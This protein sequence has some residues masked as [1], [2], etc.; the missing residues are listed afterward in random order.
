MWF[1]GNILTLY[2]VFFFWENTYTFCKT[3][4]LMMET[5]SYSVFRIGSD[6]QSTLMKPA[7]SRLFVFL[8]KGNNNCLLYKMFAIHAGVRGANTLQ[9]TTKILHR[10]FNFVEFFHTKPLFFPRS[11]LSSNC[12][13]LLRQRQEVRYDCIITY[14]SQQPARS[15]ACYR[16]L[17]LAQG[18]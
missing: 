3:M 1:A 6:I 17:K 12:P 9:N 11:L 4:Y 7:F 2:L 16:F 10:T 18:A 14:R 15:I 13:Q 5:T 8:L